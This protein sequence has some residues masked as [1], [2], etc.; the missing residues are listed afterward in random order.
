MC[1]GC[2][3]LVARCAV[4][5]KFGAYRTYHGSAM[6]PTIQAASIGR[7]CDET[8]VAEIG[9]RMRKNLTGCWRYSGRC[10]DHVPDASFTCGYAHRLPIPPSR[11]LYRDYNVTVLPAAIWRVPRRV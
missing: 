3:P 9:L 8:H 11:T 1:R 7:W 5:A 6:N 4:I 10:C 2:A